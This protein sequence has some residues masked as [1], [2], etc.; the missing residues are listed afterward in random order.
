MMTVEKEKRAS[1]EKA[2]TFI[3]FSLAVSLL[4]QELGGFLDVS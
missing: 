4:I 2:S 1:P 3:Q